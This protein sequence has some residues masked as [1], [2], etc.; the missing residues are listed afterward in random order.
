MQRKILLFIIHF[1]ILLTFFLALDL[2]S[3]QAETSSGWFLWYNSH[4]SN[5]IIFTLVYILRSRSDIKIYIYIFF[6][7][8]MIRIISSCR[9]GPRRFGLGLESAAVF[10][11]ALCGK[12]LWPA[13]HC[14][15]GAGSNLSFSHQNI[16]LWPTALLLS[17]KNLVSVLT[18][19]EN[20]HSSPLIRRTIKPSDLW[21]HAISGFQS[22][23][24]TCR[25][26]LSVIPCELP[27]YFIFSEA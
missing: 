19:G 7:S 26:L 13:P 3:K 23:G 2:T 8:N 10:S 5:L 17:L 20:R 25:Y 9:A 18:R 1:S 12:G 11:I 22:Q 27:G 24:K 6:L 14:W 16:S 21:P 4:S 15:A